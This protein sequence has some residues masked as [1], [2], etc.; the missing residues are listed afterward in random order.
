MPSTKKVQGV[1]LVHVPTGCGADAYADELLKLAGV[2][3]FFNRHMARESLQ[4]AWSFLK[5]KRKIPA[6]MASPRID[7]E[8][9]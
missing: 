5:I 6:H 1:Q 7:L 8:E 4:D 9:V 2:G 3:V